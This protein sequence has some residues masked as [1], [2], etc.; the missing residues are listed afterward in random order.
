MVE[1]V[2]GSFD[3]ATFDVGEI[4]RGFYG[5]LRLPSAADAPLSKTAL[6][7]QTTLK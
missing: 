3:P 2:G 7:R 5:G 4:N 1:C 6:T